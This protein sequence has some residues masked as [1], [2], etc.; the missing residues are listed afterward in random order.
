MH[1]YVKMTHK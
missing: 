1:N